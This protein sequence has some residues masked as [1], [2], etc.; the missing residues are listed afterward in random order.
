MRHRGRPEIDVFTS[1]FVFETNFQYLR[2]Q[3]MPEDWPSS[4]LLF[5]VIVASV[6]QLD[7]T[8]NKKA[9]GR[10]LRPKSGVLRHPYF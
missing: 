3:I 1:F 10:I 7:K 9:K 6:F 5:T 4:Y 2:K 8:H